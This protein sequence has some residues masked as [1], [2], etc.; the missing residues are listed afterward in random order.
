MSVRARPLPASKRTNSA[1]KAP[2]LYHLLDEVLDVDVIGSGPRRL[3]LRHQVGAG[4]AFG[5]QGKRAGG[6]EHV[7]GTG[8]FLTWK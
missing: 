7:L 6:G 5:G 3:R 4:V 1:T 2:C 8:L